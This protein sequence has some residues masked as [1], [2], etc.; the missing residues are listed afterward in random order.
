MGTINQKCH[1]SLPSSKKNFS[2]V[3]PMWISGF[4]HW[5]S[6]TF[7]REH[8]ICYLEW[9]WRTIR[10]NTKVPLTQ[11]NQA[12]RIPFSFLDATGAWLSVSWRTCSV[13]AEGRAQCRGDG[14]EASHITLH[15]HHGNMWCVLASSINDSILRN[16]H[17]LKSR[18][19]WQ[20]R[21]FYV[22]VL[23]TANIC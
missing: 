4:H 14:M 22:C 13:W 18:I 20:I 11:G 9:L 2:F 3:R 15:S 1:L 5:Q 10:M 12:L 7:Q 16:I 23:K 17:S 8:C 6:P 19:P 21:M